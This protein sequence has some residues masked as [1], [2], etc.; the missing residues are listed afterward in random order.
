MESW[1]TPA[2]LKGAKDNK[3]ATSVKIT[4]GQ[5]FTLSLLPTPSV[6]YP[7]RPEKPGGSVSHGGLASFTVKEAGT[8]RVALGAGA[9]V[10]VVKDGKSAQSVNHGRGP[11]C[12]GIRKMVDYALTPG[13]YVLQ[14]AGNGTNN[15]T[16]LVTKL[17]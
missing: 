2:A 3:S 17:P 9:W 14:I 6:K 16:A 7:L 5:A 12:T 10:D 1:A 8:W 15:I 4:P 13:D 11:A